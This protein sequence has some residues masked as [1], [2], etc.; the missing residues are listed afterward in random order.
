MVLRMY[1][2]RKKWNLENGVTYGNK[3]ANIANNVKDSV[4]KID[5]F[6]ASIDKSMLLRRESSSEKLLEIAEISA[7]STVRYTHKHKW[8]QN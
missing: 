7:Q 5:T 1:A 2:K 6:T 8:S 4:P 3:H